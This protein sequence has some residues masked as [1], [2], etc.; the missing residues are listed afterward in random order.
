MTDI[1]KLFRALADET[2]QDILRLLL[3]DEL[4][5]TD[6]CQKFHCT[7]PTIS[8]HL[9]ILKNCDLVDAR[10]EGKMIYYRVKKEVINDA[11]G[12]V[13]EKFHIEIQE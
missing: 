10:K 13:I 2:R 12:T 8:H 4:N 3:E 9:N 6:I 11:F 1:V 7:Q 5:V